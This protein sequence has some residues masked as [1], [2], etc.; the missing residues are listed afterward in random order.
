MLRQNAEQ[1]SLD[2]YR[3]TLDMPC[4]IAVMTYAD[5]RDL[6]QQLYKAY[7]TRASDEAANEGFDNSAIMVEIL[8]LRQQKAALIG[9]ENYAE[10]S[11]QTKMAASPP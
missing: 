1:K 11:L 10:Y 4:Y 7:S 5:D 2:G 9:F 8:Q 3:L 6:R